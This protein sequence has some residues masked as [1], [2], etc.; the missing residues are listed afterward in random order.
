MK[1]FLLL[2]SI[3]C[4]LTSAAPARL[5]ETAK[6]IQAR[7]PAGGKWV[8]MRS[9]SIEYMYFWTS[10]EYNVTISLSNLIS[11]IEEYSKPQDHFDEQEIQ[12]ILT[13]NAGTS[14]W[15]KVE[16]ESGFIDEVYRR[17]DGRAHAVH[18]IWDRNLLVVTDEIWRTFIAEYNRDKKSKL[19]RF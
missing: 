10:T 6:Q 13:A 12:V 17:A 9:T 3:S 14:T 7:Y 11:V 19:N 4:L 15:S 16:S 1:T 2:I 18:A 8:K 5:G